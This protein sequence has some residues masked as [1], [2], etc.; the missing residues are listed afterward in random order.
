MNFFVPVELFLRR[1]NEENENLNYN[2]N[3][4]VRLLRINLRNKLNILE[5]PNSKFLK[6]FRVTKETFLSILDLLELPVGVRSTYIPPILQLAATLN[7][8]GGGAYQRQVGADWSAP[9][10]QST[11]C[12]VITSTLRKMETKLCPSKIKFSPT[13]MEGTKR[14]F[15]EKYRIPGVIGCIDG[16]HIMLLRPSE[17]EHIF[18]NRKGRHSIN[19]MI[20]CD[21]NTKILAINSKYGGSAHDSFVW[22]QSAQR[23][24]MNTD[25]CA[26]SSSTWLLG[27]SGYPLEPFLLTPYRSAA[28]NSP[29][30]WFNHVHS[31]ARSTV[32]RCI[33]VMKTRWRCIL[34]E[35]K[36]R[37][38]PKRSATI[39]NVC[40]ALHNIC[41]EQRV[42]LP[43]EVRRVSSSDSLNN[44]QP[45]NSSNDGI[46]IRNRIRDDLW[47]NRTRH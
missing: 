23:E 18:F 36:L 6:N 42:P 37:Y 47:A 24:K 34:E 3:R 8:L 13:A 16:S 10:G 20:I 30:A 39:V 32:E 44:R 33:G 46:R 45:E 17:N 9:M 14:Y 19:A 43:D 28:E 5:L 12:E 40:A 26:G 4:N 25:Y 22:R 15:Y 41:C 11:V 35:R 31:Q 27:D 21:E 7:F 29:E 2:Y 1:E 38:S